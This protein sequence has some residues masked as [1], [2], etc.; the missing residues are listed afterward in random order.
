MRINRIFETYLRVLII[1]E[2]LVQFG[3]N[4]FH[5][6]IFLLFMLFILLSSTGVNG[7]MGQ[8][9]ADLG[10]AENRVLLEKIL[11]SIKIIQ[12]FTDGVVS[13]RYLY[14]REIPRQSCI[15]LY[16]PINASSTYSIQ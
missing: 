13:T 3:V 1:L 2:I 16:T 4:E 9:M 7:R 14:T 6:Y 11:F 5:L 12:I 8:V 10:L 15:I